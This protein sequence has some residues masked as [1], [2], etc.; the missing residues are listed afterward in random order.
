MCCACQKVKQ[1]NYNN[2]QV[3]NY[4]LH[5]ML[6][7]EMYLESPSSVSDNKGVDEQL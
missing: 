7:L 2:A 4:G 3:Y 6:H 5:T 1:R